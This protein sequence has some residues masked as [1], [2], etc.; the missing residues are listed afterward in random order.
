[1]LDRYITEVDRSADEVMLE[2]SLD[3]VPLGTFIS[4]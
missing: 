2:I 4:A 3:A 1:M